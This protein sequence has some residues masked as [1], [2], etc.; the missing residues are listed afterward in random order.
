GGTRQAAAG[1]AVMFSLFAINVV[2]AKVLAERGWHTWDR[3]RA[4]PASPAELLAGKA[5]PMLAVL[6]FQQAVVPGTAPAPGARPPPRAAPAAAG[7]AGDRDRGRMVGGLRAD[8]RDGAG[9]AGTH[10]RPAQHQ[11]RH[12]RDAD[13]LPGRRAGAAV[14]D[15]RLGPSRR[16]GVAG[17]LGDAG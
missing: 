16:A 3:L 15:A 5:L 10:A 14:D 6:L 2:G 1:M 13:H 11:R 12:R 7:G 17:L 4:T 8:A 9:R